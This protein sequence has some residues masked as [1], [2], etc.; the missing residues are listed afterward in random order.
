MGDHEND[1]LSN[2][3]FKRMFNEVYEA[4]VGSTLHGTHDLIIKLY[5]FPCQGWLLM[6]RQ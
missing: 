5:N 2:M 1:A 3:S 6:Y 4:R